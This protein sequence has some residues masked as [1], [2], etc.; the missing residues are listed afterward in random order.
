MITVLLGNFLVSKR[1]RAIVP[2]VVLLI[3]CYYHHYH[4]CRHHHH[5]HYHNPPPLHYRASR[6]FRAI[7][8][9][10]ATDLRIAFFSWGTRQT[11]IDLINMLI[12]DRAF[13]NSADVSFVFFYC[14]MSWITGTS[15]PLQNNVWACSNTAQDLGSLFSQCIAPFFVSDI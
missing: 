2:M 3:N 14:L 12:S 6:C 4:L 11:A 7:W 8:E 15:S 1:R 13:W 5:H 10:L 9:S